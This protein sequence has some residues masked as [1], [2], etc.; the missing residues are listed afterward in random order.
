VGY[1][2]YCAQTNLGVSDLNRIEIIGEKISD[3]KKNYRLSDNI[4]SQLIWMNPVG[5]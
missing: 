4:N 3:H 5:A 1:L 2:T